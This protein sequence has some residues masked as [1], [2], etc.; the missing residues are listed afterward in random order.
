MKKL[1]RR[2]QQQQQDQQN[3]QRLSTGKLAPPPSQASPAR[4]LQLPCPWNDI[5]GL[6]EAQSTLIWEKG[7]SRED[8]T[9]RTVR[10]QRAL[11]EAQNCGLQV[12]LTSP[13]PLCPDPAV[14]SGPVSGPTCRVKDTLCFSSSLALLLLGKSVS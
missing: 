10:G 3:T 13:K 11:A 9:M 2:Q 12:A 6:P 7:P 14:V 8:Q 1:A 4:G 5:S